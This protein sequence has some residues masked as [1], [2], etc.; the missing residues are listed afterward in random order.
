MIAPAC[1]HDQT[2]KFGKDRKGNPRV[3]C[4]LCGKTWTVAAPSLLGNMRLD[5]ARA[6]MI[7]KCLCEG[8]SARVAS[9]LA[10]VDRQ[11]VLDLM[12]FVGERCARFMQNTI[13]NVSV[14]DIQIDEVWQ[15]IGC[16]QRTA[17]LKKYGPE[18]GDSYCFTAIERNTKLLVAWH[19][20]KRDGYNCDMFCRKLSQATSGRFHLSSDGFGPYRDSVPRAL[21]GRVDFGMLI[22]IFG[23]SSQEDQRQYSPAKIIGT[24][25]EAV[26]NLPKMDRICTSHV[27]RQNL[28]FR[29][30]MRRMTRLSNGFSK[31]WRNHEAMLALYICH[32]NFCRVHGTLKTTPAVASGLANHKWTVRELLE[33]SS[34]H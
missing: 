30:F 6:E 1:K 24:K 4:A 12:V 28:N 15:F 11:T 16:K 23:K 26:H 31:V 32:Y 2:R 5:L 34:T 22:K 25:K 18:V 9:R 8:T 3:Q 20:G 19:F 7:V 29:T 13:Q 17:T 21:Y 33:K 14:D 27:E 10:G